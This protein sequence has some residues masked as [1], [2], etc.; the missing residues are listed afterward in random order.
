MR[1][2]PDFFAKLMVKNAA[3]FFSKFVPVGLETMGKPHFGKTV[4]FSTVF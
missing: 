3:Q 1:L 2:D 4:F